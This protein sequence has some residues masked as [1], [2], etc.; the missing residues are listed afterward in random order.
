GGIG[1]LAVPVA[2]PDAVHDLA[3]VGQARGGDRADDLLAVVGGDLA[4]R[5]AGPPVD[6][7]HADPG[8]LLV[9]AAEDHHLAAARAHVV[10][11]LGV[12]PRGPPAADAHDDQQDQ[13][14]GAQRPG[15]PVRLLAAAG[16][17]VGGA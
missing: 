10:L 14:R 7:G 4:D 16:A 6:T 15:P 2:E 3:G 11:P 12:A 17:A 9:D 8:Q 5:D 13:D 1:L